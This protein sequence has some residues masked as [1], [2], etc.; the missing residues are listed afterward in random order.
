VAVW[1]K[2]AAQFRQT[3]APAVAVN[4]PTTQDVH[5]L[6]PVFAINL[7]AGQLE[8]TDAPAAEFVPTAQ[9]VQVALTCAKLLM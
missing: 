8:Q 6:D 1:Y 9:L 7:P 3:V 5:V 2:P 4:L